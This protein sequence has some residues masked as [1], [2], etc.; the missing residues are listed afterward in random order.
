VTEELA[1]L[2]AATRKY[3]RL[4]K[5]AKEAREEVLNQAVAALKA[6]EWPRDVVEASPFT[7]AYIRRIARDNGLD[8]A[9]PGVKP[10][11]P[12]P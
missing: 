5:K 9:K 11:K 10:A 12:R 6:G 7:D 2:R 1:K 8:P 4:T 3:E